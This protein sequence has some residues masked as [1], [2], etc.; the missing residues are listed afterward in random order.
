MAGTVV[1]EDNVVYKTLQDALNAG[2]VNVSLNDV[3]ADGAGKE[4]SKAMYDIA[5]KRDPKK[6]VAAIE[7]MYRQFVTMLDKAYEELEVHPI[8][9]AEDVF[10]QLKGMGVSRVLNTGYSRK[11]AMQLISKLKWEK[12]VHYDELVTASD[13]EKAR[14]YPDMIF[15]AMQLLGVHDAK[16]VVKVGDSIVDVEEGKNAH[17]GLTIGTTTGAHTRAQLQSAQPDHIIDGLDELIPLIA[18]QPTI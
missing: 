18:L 1:D 8:K 7:S 10:G 14:P 5:S 9:G 4:K 17:C 11:T 15:K 6:D 3:L 13:V 16:Q 12:G 2:G